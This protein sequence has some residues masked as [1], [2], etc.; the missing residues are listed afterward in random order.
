MIQI[1][2]LPFHADSTTLVQSISSW[3]LSFTIISTDVSTSPQE[4]WGQLKISDPELLPI[5]ICGGWDIEVTFNQDVKILSVSQTYLYVYYTLYTEHSGF[6]PVVTFL[7]TFLSKKTSVEA[8][9]N[10]VAIFTQHFVRNCSQ[11]VIL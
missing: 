1:N 10:V 2:T 7:R 11:F 6:N 4:F 3:P 5:H 8:N 9:V